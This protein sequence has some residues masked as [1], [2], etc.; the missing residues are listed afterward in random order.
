MRNTEPN[1]RLLNTSKLVHVA[2]GVIKNPSQQVLIALR[3]EDAD[4][5]GL[6]EFP[7][8]KVEPEESVQQALERELQEELGITVLAAT[9][10]IKITHHYE[11]ISVLLDVWS[12]EKFSGQ[13]SGCEG[14][15]IAWVALNHLQDYTFPK[16]NQAIITA[17]QLPQ[18]YAILNGSNPSKLL[19]DLNVLLSNEIKLVQARIKEMLIH[20]QKEFLKSAYRLCQQHHAKLLAN[21]A[22]SHL[23]PSL[24]HGVH[25]TSAD[26]LAS[27]AKPANYEWVAASCHNLK[28]IQHAE[29]MGVDFIVLAP[30]LTTVSHPDAI[31]LGWATFSELV[32]QTH[33]PVYA[34]GGMQQNLKLTAQQHGAQGIAGIS[35]YLEK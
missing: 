25:L 4:Q 29:K 8:G 17:T 33:I 16:A 28:E 1:T 14:Q 11:N 10:L 26:L 32:S 13:A 27:S 18:D 15:Q 34:L 9:P 7:G 31:P 24:V 21:S 30:V 35:T 23:D 3:H 12:V 22:L 5:G 2:V 19:N 6:W 20:Q